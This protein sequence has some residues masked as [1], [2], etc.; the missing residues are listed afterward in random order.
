LSYLLGIRRFG[1]TVETFATKFMLVHL[2]PAVPTLDFE[3]AYSA[4]ASFQ[5][6]LL[7]PSESSYRF[8]LICVHFASVTASLRGLGH[9]FDQFFTFCNY[10]RTIF[11]C[12]GSVVRLTTPFSFL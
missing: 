3:S 4:S 9:L 1:L 10:F 5:W 7:I 2:L 12:F 11:I 8:T 6:L